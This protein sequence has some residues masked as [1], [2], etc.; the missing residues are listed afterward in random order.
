[1]PDRAPLFL[2]STA[3]ADR[4]QFAIGAFQAA[5]LRLLDH[6]DIVER[7]DARDQVLRHARVQ[8]IAAHLAGMLREVDDGLAG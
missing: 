4:R 6:L 3:P 5:D 7:A 8:I 1:M 2:R